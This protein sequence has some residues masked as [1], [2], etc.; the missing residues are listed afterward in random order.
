MIPK[1]KGCHP[2]L[3]ILCCPVDR[4]VPASPAPAYFTSFISEAGAGGV[5]DFWAE[6]SGRRLDLT[7]SRVL[8]WYRL[9]QTVAEIDALSRHAA[10]AARP[11]ASGAGEDVS[12]YRYT[13]AL[14]VGSGHFGAQGSDVAS[15]MSGWRGQP[16]WRWCSKCESLAFWDGSRAPGVC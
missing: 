5:F 14:F 7:G 10:A 11:R 2:W 13:L 3:V 9:T 4:S 12:G 1:L 16:G 8:G 6:M 15:G